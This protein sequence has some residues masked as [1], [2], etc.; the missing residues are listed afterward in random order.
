[1]YTGPELNVHYLKKAMPCHVKLDTR[2]PLCL[3]RNIANLD[4]GFGLQ[5]AHAN[6]HE[7]ISP[8]AII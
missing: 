1:M 3:V 7:R 2:A 5:T 8:Q 6:C 4:S